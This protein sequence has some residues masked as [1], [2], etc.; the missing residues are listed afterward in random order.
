VPAIDCSRDPDRLL[1]RDGL[2]LEI[3]AVVPVAGVHDEAAYQTDIK[4][5]GNAVHRQAVVHLPNGDD[6]G[7]VRADHAQ[8]A[9]AQPDRQGR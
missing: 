3:D 8:H 4:G 5:F 2:T 1:T 6:V 7:V 9:T